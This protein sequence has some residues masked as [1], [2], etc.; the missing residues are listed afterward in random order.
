[1]KTH[2]LANKNA[3]LSHI[4]FCISVLGHTDS[5]KVHLEYLQRLEPISTLYFLV[6]D[7]CV[8][9]GEKRKENVTCI[10]VSMM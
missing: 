10:H 2:I 1:M 5:N 9:S 8:L 6:W 3:I 7:V 4:K